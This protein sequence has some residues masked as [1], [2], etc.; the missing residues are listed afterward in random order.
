LEAEGR[1]DWENDLLDMWVTLPVA[2]LLFNI[3]CV[4]AV[5]LETELAVLLKDGDRLGVCEKLK[6]EELPV[7]EIDS[8][9]VVDWLKVG[10]SERVCETLIEV[11]GL[12]VAEIDTD[13]VVDW[14]KVG[15]RE[16]V[17]ETLAEVVRLPVA[18]LDSDDVVDWLKVGVIERVWETLVDSDCDEVIVHDKVKLWLRELV[19]DGVIVFEFE[20]DWDEVG[21]AVN[22]DNDLR[23]TARIRLLD[24]SVCRCDPTETGGKIRELTANLKVALTIKAVVALSSSAMPNGPL[25]VA[26][27]PVPSEK[28]EL[29]PGCPATVVTSVLVTL[30]ALTRWFAWSTWIAR[31]ISVFE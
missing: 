9:E 24:T 29:T 15:A 18:E 13:E 11:V 21:D 12:P 10:V 23:I 30:I 25:N 6:K 8:D 27:D 22:D 16:R 1:A 20:T 31:E 28:G 7:A 17:W 26:D 14:L 5:E 3:G 4:L 2:L 19:C